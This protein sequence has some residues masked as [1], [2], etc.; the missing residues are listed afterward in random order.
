VVIIDL[1]LGSVEAAGCRNEILGFYL[2]C[3]RNDKYG[4][5]QHQSPGSNQSFFFVAFALKPVA[6]V[7]GMYSNV[8][9]N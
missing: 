2:E 5:G 3:I 9:S 7:V 6:T 8:T 1:L 4:K